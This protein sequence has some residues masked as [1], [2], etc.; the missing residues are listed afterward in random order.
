[1]LND[2]PDKELYVFCY[3]HHAQM[4]P[5]H[6]FLKGGCQAAKVRQLALETQR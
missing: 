4:S 6:V 3:E 2:H 5:V 1:M